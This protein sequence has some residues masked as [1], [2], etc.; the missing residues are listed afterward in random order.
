LYLNYLFCYTRKAFNSRGLV[1]MQQSVGCIRSI[2][3]EYSEGHRM[4]IAFILRSVS[5]HS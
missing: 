3:L 5:H 1:R 4:A 2:S